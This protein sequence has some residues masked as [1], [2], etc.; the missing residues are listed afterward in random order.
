MTGV[1]DDAGPLGDDLGDTLEGPDVG[2]IPTGTGTLQEHCLDASELL[3][4]ELGRSPVPVGQLES[5][6]SSL[7]PVGKPRAGGLAADPQ[8]GG[9]MGWPNALGKE[10]AGLLATLLESGDDLG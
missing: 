9:D 5:V 2:A 8:L 10:D 6:G 1:I 4:A 7:L 3:I